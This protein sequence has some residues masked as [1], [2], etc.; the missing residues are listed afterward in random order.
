MNLFQVHKSAVESTL[1]SGRWMTT[2][3]FA[4]LWWRCF[5]KIAYVMI[6]SQ[7]RHIHLIAIFYAG[8]YTINFYLTGV[9]FGNLLLVIQNVF[10]LS[11]PIRTFWTWQLCWKFGLERSENRVTSYRHQV[12]HVPGF[13][14]GVRDMVPYE[15]REQSVTFVDCWDQ[16]WRPSSPTLTLHKS[17]T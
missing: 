7:P 5:K 13:A 4:F 14:A 6:T 12:A 11:Y 17:V 2:S 3:R 9:N 10:W 8:L 16:W 1:W 15:I